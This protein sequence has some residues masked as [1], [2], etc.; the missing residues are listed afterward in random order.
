MQ[1][2][3]EDYPVSARCAVLGL[4]RSSYYH[5]A[6]PRDHQR[7]REAISA[8]ACRRPAYGSRR[9]AVELNRASVRRGLVVIWRDG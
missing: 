9:V 6:K 3:G 4:A 1:S 8:V 5:Q 2:L 7:L